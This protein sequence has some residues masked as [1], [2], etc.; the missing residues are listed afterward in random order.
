MLKGLKLEDDSVF[1]K[2]EL[3]S[4]WEKAN[5]STIS[6]LEDVLKK[7]DTI[8]YSR[9]DIKEDITFE[10]EVK[11]GQGSIKGFKDEDGDLVYTFKKDKIKTSSV[12]NEDFGFELSNIR[13]RSDQTK[14]NEDRKLVNFWSAKETTSNTPTPT[15][16]NTKQSPKASQKQKQSI[17]QNEEIDSIEASPKPVPNERPKSPS[18]RV[19]YDISGEKQATFAEKPAPIVSPKPQTSIAHLGRLLTKTTLKK[20]GMATLEELNLVKLKD[21][22]IIPEPRSINSKLIL[23]EK[24][25]LNYAIQKRASV[26]NAS[27]GTRALQLLLRSLQEIESNY[28]ESSSN[29]KFLSPPPITSKNIC[30]IKKSCCTN[31][32]RRNGEFH[33]SIIRQN[34]KSNT[35]DPIYSLFK[36]RSYSSG[37][38][39]DDEFEALLNK[40]IDNSVE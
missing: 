4:N 13:G 25:P 34:Q 28:E 5:S 40:A 21:K 12:I 27:R 30:F 14:A 38:Y 35:E 2:N 31:K 15:N 19:S 23:I 18:K 33:K 39:D 20:T 36:L 11:I 7:L 16:K 32:N 8:I 9:E 29:D 1:I 17:P 10:N 6:H 3:S 26:S 22:V 37:S 24:R